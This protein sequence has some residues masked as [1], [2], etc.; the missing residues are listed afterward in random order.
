MDSEALSRDLLDRVCLHEQIILVI[1]G[2]CVSNKSIYSTKSTCVTN[3]H[4]LSAAHEVETA[5]SCVKQS[6]NEQALWIYSIEDF[7]FGGQ[8][9]AASHHESVFS[10]SLGSEINTAQLLNVD[11]ERKG[12]ITCSPCYKW[13]V[14]G[15]CFES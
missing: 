10:L 1:L 13:H 11:D 2:P 12:V 8:V 9:E 7:D 6:R 4:V 3:F 5:T 14:H 15:F